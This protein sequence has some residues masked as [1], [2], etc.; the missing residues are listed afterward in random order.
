MKLRTLLWVVPGMLGLFLASAHPAFAF[1]HGAWDELLHRHV[2]YLAGGLESRVDYTGMQEDHERLRGYLQA[3]SRVTEDAFNQ[4]P[5]DEQLA[6]LINCYNAW[7]VELILTKYPELASI[8]DL[9]SLFT[10]PWQRKFVPLFDKTLSLDD[11]EHG[12]IRGSGRFHEPRIHFAVNCASVGCPAL[13]AE[14]YRGDILDM[15]LEDA[16]RQFLADRTRNRLSGDT[17]EISSV[18]R[19]YRDDFNSGWRGAVTME[20]FLALYK[21]ALGLSD[22][23]AGKLVR[24]TLAV[25]FLDYDWSLNDLRQGPDDR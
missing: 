25:R 3:L 8:K 13:R 21:Q 19:W 1:D 6:F 2:R 9:G 22:T 20:A 4:W 15:Q 10:S 5:R 23:T 16:T 14:A 18:F 12:L 11:I 7:T 24:G 17:L